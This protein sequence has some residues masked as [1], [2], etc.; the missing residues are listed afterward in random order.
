MGDSQLQ[1]IWWSWNFPH[2]EEDSEQAKKCFVLFP[3]TSLFKPAMCVVWYV[4][5]K[6][7][8]LCW[9]KKNIN[10]LKSKIVFKSVKLEH[11]ESSH[12]FKLQEKFVDIRHVCQNQQVCD[13]WKKGPGSPNHIAPL[14]RRTGV[15]CKFSRGQSHWLAWNLMTKQKTH[16][17]NL[18]LD[19]K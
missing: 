15:I 19:S 9:G 18:R 12:Q 6:N 3:D 7:G 4:T 16:F 17:L 10:F 2:Q 8:I 1:P 5:K 14:Y 11:I 13:S